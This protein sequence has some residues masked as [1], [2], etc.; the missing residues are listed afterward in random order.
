MPHDGPIRQFLLFRGE[1]L[2]G[3]LNVESADFPW[4]N[5]SFEP[6][7][8]FEECRPIFEAERTLRER[9]DM[10]DN[11]PDFAQWWTAWKKLYTPPLRA[12]APGATG[13]EGYD[14]LV[15]IDGVQARWTM[16][17]FQ[18]VDLAV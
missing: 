12:V 15:H 6:T 8:A 18:D 10:A 7:V 9:T 1:T 4:F 14:W 5:G 3:R 2:I 13:L 16:T 11:H 17:K